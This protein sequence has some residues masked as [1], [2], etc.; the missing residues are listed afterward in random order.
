M[1]HPVPCSLAR[2]IPCYDMS[3][4]RVVPIYVPVK[5]DAFLNYANPKCN[6]AGDDGV[7]PRAYLAPRPKLDPNALDTK[8]DDTK[9]SFGLS[10]DV[11]DNIRERPPNSNGD[12]ERQTWEHSGIYLHWNLPSMYR[13]GLTVSDGVEDFDDIRK[14]GGYPATAGQ[15]GPGDSPIYRQ[16]PSRSDQPYHFNMHTHFFADG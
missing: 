12:P 9:P 16:V 3:E 10:H 2:S 11:F 6:R 13:T 4:D 7:S 1:T 14:R 5:V 8:P 15:S